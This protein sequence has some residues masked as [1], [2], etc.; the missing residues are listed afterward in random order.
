MQKRKRSIALSPTPKDPT[1]GVK[2]LL[3]VKKTW[4]L[5]KQKKA[6]TVVRIDSLWFGFAKK[7]WLLVTVGKKTWLF[8]LDKKTLIAERIRSLL[9]G[10]WKKTWLAERNR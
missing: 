3:F 2:T 4:L 5:E 7:T 9:P 8:V 1:K 10:F 6:W